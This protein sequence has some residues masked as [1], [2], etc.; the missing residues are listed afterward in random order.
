MSNIWQTSEPHHIFKKRTIFE[1]A[2]Q[3]TMQRERGRGRDKEM[4]GERIWDLDWLL[5]KSL[6]NNS[7][8][9]SWRI[10]KPWGIS[11][12]FFRNLFPFP[13]RRWRRRRP[14]LRCGGRPLCG[15]SGSSRRTHPAGHAEV[16]R[17]AC[18]VSTGHRWPSSTSR[19]GSTWWRWAWPC[20]PRFLFDPGNYTQT[21]VCVMMLW[22]WIPQFQTNSQEWKFINSR[23]NP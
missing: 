16:R 10:A 1:H 20:E 22:L 17:P 9:L 14:W 4:G 13:R 15:C 18:E 3:N 6:Y 19:A 23:S 21:K 2:I 7:I 5:A 8:S 12:E 11:W